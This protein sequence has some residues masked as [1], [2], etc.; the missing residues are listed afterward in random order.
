MS[1][2]ADER[3]VSLLDMQQ[4]FNAQRANSRATV[5]SSR[6]L[7]AGVTKMIADAQAQRLGNV[8]DFLAN[9]FGKGLVAQIKAAHREDEQRPIENVWDAATGATAY[10]RGLQYQDRCVEIEREAGKM[11]AAV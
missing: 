11:L 8:D 3:F 2:P 5:V 4:H 9:R 1:R 6:R 7:T 10:A